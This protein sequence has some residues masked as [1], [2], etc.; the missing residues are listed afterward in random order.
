MC[1]S[2]CICA[3]MCTYVHVCA[4]VH[5]CVRARC[6]GGG[7][8]GHVCAQTGQY[9]WQCLGLHS[10]IGT[11]VGLTC[12]GLHYVVVHVPTTCTCTLVST[13]MYLYTIWYSNSIITR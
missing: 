13:C 9:L 2:V 1:V 8:G 11:E 10:V 3:C 4:C 7:G 12:S 6:G 5:V